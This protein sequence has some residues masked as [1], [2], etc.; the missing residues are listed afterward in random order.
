[1]VL[2]RVFTKAEKCSKELTIALEFLLLCQNSTTNINLEMTGFIYLT[3][4]ILSFGAF[5]AGT[6]IE[7]RK[8]YCFRTT[9]PEVAPHSQVSFHQVTNPQSF[10]HGNLMMTFSQP[11][12]ALVK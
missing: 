6:Y 4:S 8:E 12:F 7:A 1:M 9:Y 11:M 5:K 10:L 2:L 3:A